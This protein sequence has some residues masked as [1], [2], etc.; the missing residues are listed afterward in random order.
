MGSFNYRQSGD[1]EDF[2]AYVERAI[3]NSSVSA[4]LEER[5]DT[6]VGDA[7]MG[8]RVFER[9]SAFSGSRVSL[10]IS[11]L[12]VGAEMAV[13]VTSSG[14]S[15]AMFFK[16]DTVGESGFLDAARSV[17]AQYVAGPTHPQQ[18]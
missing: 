13:S 11:V 12:A 9:Y 1:V 4:T 14:G 5:F 7:R 10:S 18:P 3:P 17:L 6:V 8:V 2:L 16:V 15:R